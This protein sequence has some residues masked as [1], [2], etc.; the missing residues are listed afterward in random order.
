MTK[1]I[2]F[3]FLI[4]IIFSFNYKYSSLNENY[5]SS[6][7]IIYNHKK[8]KIIGTPW[9]CDVSILCQNN[10]VTLCDNDTRYKSQYIFRKEKEIKKKLKS[11]KEIVKS[12]YTCEG[13][14]VV[15]FTNFDYS[16]STI[17]FRNSEYG[18]E[19]VYTIEYHKS[20]IIIAP[21]TEGFWNE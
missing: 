1:I 4:L 11:G 15:T 6:S 13:G 10:K 7:Y 9:M 5:Y 20:S 14:R 3:I 18:D 17:G 8:Q 19:K 12:I 2:S 21:G 16:I